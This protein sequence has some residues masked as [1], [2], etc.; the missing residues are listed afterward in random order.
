MF[1]ANS[2]QGQ[3]ER[4]SESL[5]AQLDAGMTLPAHWYTDPTIYEQE[6]K[7][8]FNRAW[9]YA[10][11][12]DQVQKVGDYFSCRVGEIPVVVLRDESMKL[13]AFVNVCKHRS[14]EII[15]NG[16]SGNRRSLQ[17]HYH[18]WTWGL[19][20][21]L[22]S[23][24]RSEGESCFNRADFSLTPVLLETFGPFI[25]VNPD[26][27]G[28]PWSEVLGELPELVA[29]TGADLNGLKFRETRC[30]EMNANWKVVVENYLECY[31]C[32]I[33]HKGFASLIDLNEYEVVPYRYFSVQR[34]TV[35][36]SAKS[37]DS[38]LFDVS[39]GATEGLYSFVWPNFM[40]N[41][42]PGLGNASMNLIIPVDVNRT[43]AIF[44]FHL[45]ELIPACE[46]QKIIEFVD[47]IQA[48]DTILCESVQRGL[49][50]G[51]TPQGRLILSKENGIQHFQRLV[52]SALSAA[53][54]G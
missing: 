35:K 17:C 45:S 33:A 15:L 30:Y 8:I 2:V 5:D 22:R 47:Q 1:E 13:K 11:R 42:Y 51:K 49:R 36:E 40:V 12:L 38:K 10:G 48:E 32:P 21:E 18:A 41:T 27:D 44:D 20:G 25:F 3:G 43:L 9:H 39:A 16:T 54:N 24:P 14:A 46:A 4:L 34:G 37:G 26:S 52:L 53:G 6:L 7:R 31:H 28:L 50:S 29:A 19:D 23:A